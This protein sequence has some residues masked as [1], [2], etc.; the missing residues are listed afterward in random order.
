MLGAC[1]EKH[2]GIKIL[3]KAKK[4]FFY[5]KIASFIAKCYSD[6][7]IKCLILL[8]FYFSRCNFKFHHVEASTSYIFH[9]NI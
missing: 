4:A 7:Y 8:L 5:E 9:F 2:R 6:L 3:T 1:N